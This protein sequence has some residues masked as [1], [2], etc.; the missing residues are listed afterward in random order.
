MMNWIQLWKMPFFLLKRRGGF[1]NSGS[2]VGTAK[3]KKEL[4]VFQ[5]GSVF[6]NRFKGDI[7]DVV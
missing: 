7:Y 5:S 2:C 1:I 3:K 4:Y 6:K